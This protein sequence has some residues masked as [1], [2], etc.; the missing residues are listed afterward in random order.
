[1][2]GYCQIA[3]TKILPEFLG[4]SLPAM[5]KNL[6][7]PEAKQIKVEVNLSLIYIPK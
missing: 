3:T 2:Q 1:M 5:L 6:A 7:P 4:N